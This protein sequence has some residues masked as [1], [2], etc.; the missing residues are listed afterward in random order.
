MSNHRSSHGLFACVMLSGVTNMPTA[1]VCMVCLI[2][3]KEA[4]LRRLWC[5]TVYKKGPGSVLTERTSDSVCQLVLFLHDVCLWVC[6][7]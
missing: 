4:S 2:A 1:L 7:P 6:S 5:R 3:N